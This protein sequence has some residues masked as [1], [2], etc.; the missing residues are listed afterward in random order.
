MRNLLG[1]PETSFR[2]RR[3]RTARSVRKSKELLAGN[4]EI[5]LKME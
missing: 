4:M 1:I 3:T 2:G 5:N